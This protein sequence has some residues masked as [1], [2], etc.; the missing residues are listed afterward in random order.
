MSITRLAFGNF[1]RSIRN[2]GALLLSLSFSVFIFFNFQNVIYADSMKVLTEYNK[3][4]IDMIL[5]AASVV[6]SVF[7]FFFIW[8]ATNVFLNQRKKE[9]GIYTFMGLDNGKIGRM[10]AL[11]ASFVGLTALAAGL[12][13]GILFSR[14][15]QMLL[16]RLSEISVNIEFSVA[17]EPFIVTAAMFF[18]FYGLM[19]LKGYD[20]I[21]R[22]SVLDMLSGA[23][24]NEVIREK[25]ILT[26]LRTVSGV[27]ILGAGYLSAWQTG[28]ISS[29]EKA[30]LAVILVIAG[31]YLLYSGLIPFILRRMTANKGYLYRKERTLW[32]NNLAFRM[33]KNYRTYAMVT[34]LM[35]CSVTVLA[36]SISLK[37]RYDR[38]T[39]FQETYTYQVISS[40]ELDESK[41]EELIERKNEISY[42]SKIECTVLD[43]SLVETDYKNQTFVFAPFREIEKAAAASGLVFPYEKLERGEAVRMTH[44]ILLSLADGFEK[45]TR[46]IAGADYE[47]IAED[48]TPYFGSLQENFSIYMVNDADYETL[49]TK[50]ECLYSYNYRIKNLKNAD[51]SREDLL[52]LTKSSEDGGAFTGVNYSS[53]GSRQEAWI[54]V[55]YS[56]CLF[57]FA[58]L[59]LAGGS[60]LFI[61]LENEAWEDKERYQV[62]E[63]LGIQKECLVRS[64]KK[65]IRFAYYCP[66]F[67][68]AVTSFFSVKALENVMRENLLHVNVIS[69]TSIFLL[70]TLIYVVSV[71]IFQRKIF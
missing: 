36:M 13:C 48:D 43:S 21:V 4:Y 28:D 16:L 39:H 58:T 54:R 23:K 44:V 2:Y 46:K 12:I 9:I 63:K 70:F 32:V 5:Q 20:T 62:L 10:Y 59:I 7:L 71:R 40:G 41:I 1:R 19:V 26:F 3:E 66:F 38:M 49:R 34:I 11:E 61:K 68:M 8:Y 69:S 52:E 56:L 45:E 50:G 17:K 51:A 25:G 53:A 47:I 55:M 24:H 18:C 57:M 30:L 29:L 33:K 6:F 42:K 31:V 35:I 65:E 14:L 15:F 64:M 37:L 27:V 67:L 60:I 22:S